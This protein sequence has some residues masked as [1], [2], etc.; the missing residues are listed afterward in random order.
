M[1]FGKELIV[2]LDNCKVDLSD[3][4]GINDLINEMCHIGNMTKK[5][6]PLIEYFEDN[7]F[8]R[9]RDIVGYS[10]CQ[11]ISLSNITFH[12]NDISR[13]VYINFFTC[14]DLKIDETMEVIINYF[15]PEKNKFIVITR[16][17]KTINFF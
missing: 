13:T 12:L 11:V 10:I 16:D 6:N 1:V 7:E 2:D 5:G 4:N 15:K 17:A 8:N 3:I 14:G 9:D